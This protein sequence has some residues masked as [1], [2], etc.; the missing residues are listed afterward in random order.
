M[1][2]MRCRE[3]GIEQRLTKSDYPWTNSQVARM[4]RTLKDATVKNAIIAKTRQMAH[5]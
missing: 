2:D 3:N 4:N 5:A 1:L